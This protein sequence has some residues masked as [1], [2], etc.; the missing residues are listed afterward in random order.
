LGVVADKGHPSC[1]DF[2]EKT[3][4]KYGADFEII[5]DY[6]NAAD[7]LK[8]SEYIVTALLEAKKP[9]DLL[10]NKKLAAYQKE[11]SS[12][13]SRLMKLHKGKAEFYKDAK[14]VVYD[15]DT[16]YSLRGGIANQMQEI[17]TDWTVI[18]GEKQGPNYAMSLRTG[19][20]PVDLVKII[21]NSILKLRSASGG[22]HAKAS[23]CKVLYADRK[24]FL[25]NFVN[26]LIEWGA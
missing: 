3:S 17:Y 15:I 26:A 12:E 16:E 2:L 19:A 18:I 7:V 20:G 4:K 13:V 1:P 14:L 25:K 6:T 21:Q 10:Q 9:Q 22:G 11:F 8:D 23:G 5:K 24:I